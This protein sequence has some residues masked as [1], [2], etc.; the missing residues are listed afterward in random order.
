MK[1]T[2]LRLL[3][4]VT[5]LTMTS[6]LTSSTTNEIVNQ[7]PKPIA[8]KPKWKSDFVEKIWFP[9]LGNKTVK[10]TWYY[11]YNTSSFRIDREDGSRDRY[12]GLIFP[13]S[14]TECR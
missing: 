10:G 8:W 3:T 7:N 5:L 12:C 1:K 13:L 9:L 11:N 4:L 2:L 14:K 6:V